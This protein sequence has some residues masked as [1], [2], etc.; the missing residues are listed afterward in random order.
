MIINLDQHD[1]FTVN[2]VFH[3]LHEAIK[4]FHFRLSFSRLSSF[5]CSLM[6][7]SG[8]IRFLPGN[9]GE[10]VNCQVCI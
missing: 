3:H 6:H 5:F 4:I 2:I 8:I 9:I 1:F 7:I 10:K